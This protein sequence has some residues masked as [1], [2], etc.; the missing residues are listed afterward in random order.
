MTRL[1]KFGGSALLL[2]LVTANASAADL[3]AARPYVKAPA[4]AEAFSWSGF[5]VGANGGYGWAGASTTDAVIRTSTSH[6]ATGGLAGA[7]IGYN[8]QVAPWVFGIEAD[9]DWASIK[10]SAPCPNVGFNCGSET[11]ALA[12]LRGRI[13]WASGP[14]LL[15]ATGGLG[16]ASAR[17]MA[18]TG[19]AGLPVVGVTGSFTSD[20][21][22]WALGG[23]V[24]YGF[25]RNWSA[26]LEYLHYGFNDVTMPP[27]ALSAN[28]VNASLRVD[29][30]KV[31]INYHFGAN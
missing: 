10:G 7:Q 29:T 6:T 20:R 17:Y 12:S 15:Y 21:W 24:E 30:I 2:L 13:G 26:K 22:G 16:Y 31:G 9:G 18:T 19:A 8:W 3:S 27:G 28:P 5:Y 11:Q 25:A 14:T 4:A 23:G 1:G